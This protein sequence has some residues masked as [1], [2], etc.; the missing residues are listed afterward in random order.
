MTALAGSVLAFTTQLV[1]VSTTGADIP[2]SDRG[3]NPLLDS[4]TWI[5]SYNG[6]SGGIS[7]TKNDLPVDLDTGTGEITV[8][9]VNGTVVSEPTPL[10]ILAPGFLFLL[11]MRS[12]KRSSKIS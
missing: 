6:T 2:L 7:T 12:W 1:G 8:L 10:T 5:D 3:L 4:F 11:L 9:S